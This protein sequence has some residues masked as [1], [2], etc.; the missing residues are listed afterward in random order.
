[1]RPSSI[2]VVPL[3]LLPLLLAS[4]AAAQRST[5]FSAEIRGGAAVP[6][7]SFRRVADVGWTAGAGAVYRFTR[8][9]GVF[10][11]Y[12][13]ASMDSKSDATLGGSTLDGSITTSAVRTGVQWTFPVSWEHLHPYLRTGVFFGQVSADVDSGTGSRRVDADRLTSFSLGVG[14][15]VSIRPKIA[16]TPGIRY[17]GY[18]PR[19]QLSGEES[20]VRLPVRYLS[21]TLGVRV[22]P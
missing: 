8:V 16:I 12:D 7:G 14:A 18:S 19:F 9:V 5:P 6:V 10:L 20:D 3:V 21:L 15:D 17:N 13:R 4:E 11:D 22:S 1:M 2:R